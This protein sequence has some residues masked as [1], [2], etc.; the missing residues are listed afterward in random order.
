M[1]R[2]IIWD[3]CKF[4]DCNTLPLSSYLD[5]ESYEITFYF[6]QTSHLQSPQGVNFTHIN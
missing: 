2:K 4:N 3:N 1:Q 5:S 6:T